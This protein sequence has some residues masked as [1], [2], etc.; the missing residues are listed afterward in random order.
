MET[1]SSKVSGENAYTRH[2]FS[3]ISVQN[4][5]CANDAAGTVTIGKDSN[6]GDRLPVLF[7]EQV[8]IFGH[9]LHTRIHFK[10]IRQEFLHCYVILFGKFATSFTVL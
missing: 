3:T 5:Q 8:R 4:T 1:S 10:K 2:I 6:W 7:R 9:F